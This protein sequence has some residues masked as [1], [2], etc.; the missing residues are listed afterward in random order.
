MSANP[1][2]P[3]ETPSHG[4]GP[5]KNRPSVVPA[6]EGETTYRFL[7]IAFIVCAA[8]MLSCGTLNWLTRILGK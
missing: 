3:P 5:S 6:I 1:Q 8:L 4:A 2:K 7:L